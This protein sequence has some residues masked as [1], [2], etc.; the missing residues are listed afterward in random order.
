MVPSFQYRGGIEDLGDDILS[1]LACL[2]TGTAS[3]GSSVAGEATKKATYDP[4]ASRFLAENVPSARTSATVAA[5]V[6]MLMTITRTPTGSVI[7]WH[8][9]VPSTSP[10]NRG[11][12]QPAPSA[13]TTARNG[14][15]P[16]DGPAD[17]LRVFTELERPL[18]LAQRFAVV[19]DGQ[20]LECFKIDRVEN[21]SGA[22]IGEYG[23]DAAGMERTERR[24][25]VILQ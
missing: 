12:T 25:V 1:L 9:T 14:R 23:G 4:G 24:V 11:S 16:L 7:P 3:G 5:P 22:A 6:F 18:K 10:S 17:V 2:R 20:S 19:A 15:K 13:R 21:E 8:C